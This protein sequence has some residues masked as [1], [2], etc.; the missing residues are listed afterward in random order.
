MSVSYNPITKKE[1]I[2]EW[3]NEKIKESH[4]K[5]FEIAEALDR[6]SSSVT[7]I[8]QSKSR[9]YLDDAIDLCILL[10]LDMNELKDFYNK[11]VK[12]AID[13]GTYIEIKS[14]KPP[15]IY[16]EDLKKKQRREKMKKEG[17]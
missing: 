17:K 11:E 2:A 4:F 9:T 1:I 14:G 8:V 10:D 15:M 3:F 7:N 12:K 13:D 5:K 16:K 6:S